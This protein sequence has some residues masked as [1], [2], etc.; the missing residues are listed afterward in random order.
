MP[1]SVCLCNNRGGVGKTFMAFQASAALAVEH[2]DRKVLAVD[3]SIYSD[4]SALYL[5]GTVSKEPLE[6]S[7]GLTVAKEKIPS[8]KRVESL[9]RALH[10]ASHT[11]KGIFGSIVS[12]FTSP[13]VDLTRYAV[14][15]ADY[16]EEAPPNLYLIASAGRD[17][18]GEKTREYA[19]SLGSHET[20]LMKKRREAGQ[21]L[22]R[23]VDALPEEFCAV[24]FDTDHLAG[25]PLTRLALAAATS[26]VVPCPT[27]T[28][29]FHRLYRTPDCDQFDGVESLFGDVMIPMHA[30]GML[31]AKVGSMIFTK[32]P[33]TKNDSHITAGGVRCSFTPTAIMSKQMDSLAAMTWSVIQAH[34]EYG[35]LFEAAPDQQT[36]VSNTFRTFKMVSDVARNVS[37]SNGVPIARMTSRQYTTASGITGST[38]S[39]VLESLQKEIASLV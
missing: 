31:R 23:A 22:R 36:F 39:A 13:S 1:A 14:R 35:G 8:E 33:S 27:D 21:T 10:G 18:Y 34:P 17:S 4:L 9:L 24:V 25:S 5:G 11:S 6:A 29:E 28:A 37:V 16:N 32:V 38:A 7:V 26:C 12:K 3:F 19:R 30:E 2:P 20:G 15:V